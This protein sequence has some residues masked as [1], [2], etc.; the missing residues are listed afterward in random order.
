MNAQP[1]HSANPL[2]AA[3]AVLA[4]AITGLEAILADSCRRLNPFPPFLGMATI[5]AVEVESPHVQTGDRGCVV[6]T[7]DGSISELEV[8]AI[9]G[10]V[11][12]LEVDQVE[13]FKP[14]DTAPEEYFL[15]L[16]AAVRTLAAE[17]RRRGG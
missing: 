4:Q 9:P 11:G 10:I 15:Y 7:P 12:V 6:V 1:D 13:Q 14:L 16:V 2:E 5:Q 8:A 3:D 17:L